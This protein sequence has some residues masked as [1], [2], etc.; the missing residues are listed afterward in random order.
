VGRFLVKGGETVWLDGPLAR[1]VR[2]GDICYLD[3]IV[4]AHEATT[5][6]IHPLADERWVLPVEKAGELLETPED[7]RLA[8]SF[9]PGYQSVLEDLKQS[10]RQRFAASGFDDPDAGLEERIS[11]KETGVEPERAARLAKFAHMTRNLKGQRPDEGA[12]T[13]LLV[14]AAKPIVAGIESITACGAAIAQALTDDAEMLAA[15]NELGS[16]FRTANGCATSCFSGGAL[17]P[18]T[19]CLTANP[20][21]I[22]THLGGPT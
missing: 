17:A 9:N 20:R 7:F 19:A 8:I 16:L 18:C 21:N 10:T 22:D 14:H 3:E 4:E 12:S 13:L 15:V 1:A 2:A 6:V 11:A 5:A